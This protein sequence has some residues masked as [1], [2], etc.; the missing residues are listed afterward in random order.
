MS[1]F[2]VLVG[3]DWGS[4]DHQVALVDVTGQC[5]DNRSFPHGGAGLLAMAEWI[6]ARTGATAE[7]VGVAIEIPH[8]P[9]VE[10]MMERGFAVHSLN[11]K[12][13]DR[14][15]DRF[16][17]AGAKDDSR[18]ALTLADALR[19]DPRFFRRLEPDTAAVTADFGTAPEERVLEAL[20]ADGWLHNHGDPDSA[21]GRA[22]KAEIRRCFHPDTDDWKAMAQTRAGDIEGRMI[23]GL[24]ALD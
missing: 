19:T 11:P 7:A 14:L 15:R 1:E 10:A 24:A 16:S 17:P 21:E 13:L 9:V 4:C 2:N 22:I 23:A 18:D 5:L 3:I 12:Q 8:G 20:C 6:L